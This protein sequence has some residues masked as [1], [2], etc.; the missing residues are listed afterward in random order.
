MAT[1]ETARG[2]VGTDVLGATLMHEHVLIESIEYQANYPGEWDEEVRITDAVDRLDH[3]YDDGISTIVDLTIL[4][5]GRNVPRVAEIAA[6]TKL[7]IIVAAGV[8]ALSELPYPFHTRNPASPLGG[9]R[10][11]LDELFRRDVEDGVAGTNIKVGILKCTTDRSG[12]TPDVERAVRAIARAHRATGVPITTHSHAGTRRGLEQQDVFEGEGV[13]LRR[14]VI[15]HSGD[16]TDIEYL[17]QIISRG[18]YVGMDRFGI[19][20]MLDFDQRVGTVAQLCQRGHADHVVLSHDASCHV[21]WFDERSLG[22]VLPN[23]NFS[24]ISRDVLPALRR[25][26]VSEEQITT[27]LVDNPRTFFETSGA[28]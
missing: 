11:I 23:W 14:V 2:P 5:Q 20:A 18:S 4:G 16:T 9:G 15:G 22:E 19:D 13:D 10:E 25:H 3:L 21:D 12:M 8:Y 27:M 17:E 24:H 1:V 7:N 28:Y 26:G 6:R